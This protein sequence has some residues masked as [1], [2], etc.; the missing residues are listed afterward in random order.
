MSSPLYVPISFVSPISEPSRPSPHSPTSS[1]HIE[2][3]NTHKPSHMRRLST[4]LKH[5][6]TLEDATSARRRESVISDA[7]AAQGEAERRES[8]VS[9]QDEQALLER[10]RGSVNNFWRKYG[11]EGGRRESVTNEEGERA[12]GR[13][14]SSVG[15]GALESGLGGRW[16][17]RKMSWG[18]RRGST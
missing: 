4:Y 5:A 11:K 13:R 8:V 12:D 2:S 17:G 9:F 18:G 3:T 6:F 16:I 1:T 15:L 10:R 7:G 14:K